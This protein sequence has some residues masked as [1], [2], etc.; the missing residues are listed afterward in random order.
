MCIE[1]IPY[2]ESVDFGISLDGFVPGRLDRWE[3]QPKPRPGKKSQEHGNGHGPGAK[4]GGAVDM[5]MYQD[6]QEG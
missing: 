4:N 6:F 1:N 3:W 5:L 2:L